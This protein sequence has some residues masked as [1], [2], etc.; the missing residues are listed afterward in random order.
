MTRPAKS[1]AWRSAAR[2]IRGAVFV[3]VRPR[4]WT[5]AGGSALGTRRAGDASSGIAAKIDRH[6]PGCLAASLGA[7]DPAS[8]LIAFL[9]SHSKIVRL[10][11]Q[12]LPYRSPKRR[13]GRRRLP[14]RAHAPGTKGKPEFRRAKAGVRGWFAQPRRLLERRLRA[15]A[16]NRKT[17]RRFRPTVA[18]PSSKIR[19][20][21]PLTDVYGKR[22][23][24][25]PTCKTGICVPTSN[26]FAR[27]G[28]SPAAGP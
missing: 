21:F 10:A 28:W 20:F 17:R 6:A 16:G 7:G 11:G 23:N 14:A 15:G 27:P 26:W 22:E 13:A 4:P 25:V 3:C 1:T 24:S 2:Q 9:M 12:S 8:D 19:G 18:I 5:Q